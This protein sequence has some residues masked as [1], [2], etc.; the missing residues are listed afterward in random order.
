MSSLCLWREQPPVK[1][2][3]CGKRR[4]QSEDDDNILQNGRIFGDNNPR[5]DGD[6]KVQINTFNAIVIFNSQAHKCHLHIYYSAITPHTLHK[7]TLNLTKK[8]R[9]K[10][11]SW[12]IHGGIISHKIRRSYRYNH[13]QYLTL[14]QNSLKMGRLLL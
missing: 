4:C 5:S 7:N 1:I 10:A 6:E 11:L 12:I 3:N 8:R 9:H 13:S 2:G 14:P